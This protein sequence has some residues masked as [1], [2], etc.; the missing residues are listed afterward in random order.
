L[1]VVSND[2]SLDRR[3][4]GGVGY[5]SIDANLEGTKSVSQPFGVD[6]IA[7]HSK[8]RGRCSE[9]DEVRHDVAGAAQR[10]RLALDLD[11]R[12]GSFGRD[13]AHSAPDE[14]VQH[15][16]AKHD[17]PLAVESGSQRLSAF[18]G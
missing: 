1:L 13:S 11:D 10:E 18:T 12:D 17:D 9:R 2:S 15:Q 6:V 16:V 7:D 5:Q 14:L 8:G 4:A 3:R